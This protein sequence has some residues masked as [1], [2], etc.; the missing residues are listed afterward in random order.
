M[1]LKAA[2]GSEIVGGTGD[3]VWVP[4]LTK[5]LVA[6]GWQIIDNPALAQPGDIA[7]EAGQHDGGPPG[8]TNP[9]E[10]HIGVVVNDPNGGSAILNNSSGNGSFTN[11]DKTMTFAAPGYHSAGLPPRFYR[12]P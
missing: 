4:D 12:S 2:T 8:N 11:L 6:A 5:G 7:V 1:V 10:T 9:Y 3:P